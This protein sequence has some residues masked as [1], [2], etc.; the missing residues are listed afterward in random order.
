VLYNTAHKNKIHTSTY[1]RHKPT[2]QLRTTHS[3]QL[4]HGHMQPCSSYRCGISLC[5]APLC[6]A[7]HGHPVN[8]ATSC[9][10]LLHNA[11][12][13]CCLQ[14]CRMP[15]AAANNCCKLR[16]CWALAPV[17]AAAQP[18]CSLC[19]RQLHRCPIASASASSSSSSSSH[20][21]LALVPCV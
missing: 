12:T 18:R 3:Y 4:L 20:S 14:R 21:R 19:L 5:T 2:G 13:T 16:P 8:C 6:A 11:L 17:P 15:A 1:A 9:V 7:L 10:P